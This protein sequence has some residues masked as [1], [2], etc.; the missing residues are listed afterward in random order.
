MKV[1]VYGETWCPHSVNAA[2]AASVPLTE[3]SKM[4]QRVRTAVQN[5][6][7]VTIPVCVVDGVF[8]GGYA[9]LAKKLRSSTTSRGSTKRTKKTKTPAQTRSTKNARKA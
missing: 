3:Y 7:H 2:R 5:S 8:I 4:P 6:Q 1:E 9:E